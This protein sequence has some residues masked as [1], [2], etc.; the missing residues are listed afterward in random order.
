[1]RDYLLMHKDTPVL[2]FEMDPSDGRIYA[3]LNLIVPDKAPFGLKDH[4]GTISRKSLTDWWEGRTI[5]A[6]RSGFSRILM[7]LNI[8]KSTKLLLM[9]YGLS[10]N[11]QYWIKEANSNL[12]W[13]KINF[14]ENEFSEDMGR[15]L[16]GEYI[17]NA[18]L[19]SP[20]NTSDGWL[21]KKWKI[22]NGDRFLLKAGSGE[23]LQEPLNEAIVS[24]INSR[25]G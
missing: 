12:N 19:K 5:P 1:M 18:D 25:T 14:F 11:D 20:D 4:K 15:I 21:K 8:S 17:N 13:S 22:I 24:I 10:L 7:D 2:E 6:S 9:C 23:S 16:F 3:I